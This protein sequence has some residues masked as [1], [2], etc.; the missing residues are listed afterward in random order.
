MRSSHVTFN[1]N[2]RLVL[3]HSKTLML[4]NEN[5]NENENENVN[6]N[7]N[8]RERERENQGEK[9]HDQTRIAFHCLS[10]ILFLLL[11]QLNR[12]KIQI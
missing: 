7:V 8:V 4:F 5:E 11:C 2:A 1:I 3:F 9:K 6:E 12:E 10:F